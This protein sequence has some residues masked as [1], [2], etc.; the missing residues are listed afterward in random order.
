M[1]G[2]TRPPHARAGARR[3]SDAAAGVHPDRSTDPLPRRPRPA[4]PGEEGAP[5]RRF[6]SP[7]RRRHDRVDGDR[8]GRR[9]RGPADRRRAAGGGN[10]HAGRGT[11][12]AAQPGGGKALRRAPHGGRGLP[13]RARLSRRGDPLAAGHGQGDG[14]RRPR[15]ADPRRGQPARAGARAR[16][17]PC[18]RHPLRRPPRQ[19]GRPDE[20]RGEGWVP[21]QAADA[22]AAADAG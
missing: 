12:R 17:G 20:A 22:P 11:V 8:A 10:R 3:A 6:D 19:H 5:S 2:Y 14:P 13:L 16:G 18:Q 4:P 21:A 15:G 9:P 7:A 1:V